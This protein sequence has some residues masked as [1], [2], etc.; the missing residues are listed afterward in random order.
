MYT[1][2]LDTY[3]S[4]P[5]TSSCYLDGRYFNIVFRSYPGLIAEPLKIFFYRDND[6]SNGMNRMNGMNAYNG[7][8]GLRYDVM[9]KDVDLDNRFPG[10]LRVVIN[11]PEGRHSNLLILDYKRGIAFRYEPD[12]SNYPYFDAVNTIIARFLNKYGTFRVENIDARAHLKRNPVCEG[13]GLC[14]AYVIKFAYDYIND[15]QFDQSNILRF[16]SMIEQLYGPL[17]EMG[18]DIEYGLFGNPNPNQGQN[19]LLGGIGG[20][21]VGGILGGPVGMVA[22]GVTGGLLGSAL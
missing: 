2:N 17:P 10:L 22:G 9:M 4:F 7:Q 21:A 13:G 8:N 11:T 6:A 14:M 18:K 3:H 5:E 16:V 15:R 1:D 19:A 20:M 12:G